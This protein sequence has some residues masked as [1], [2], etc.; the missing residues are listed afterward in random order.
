MQSSPSMQS[1]SSVQYS[2]HLSGAVQ[3]AWKKDRSFSLLSCV[4]DKPKSANFTLKL[5]TSSYKQLFIAINVHGQYCLKNIN[6]K[7]KASKTII[8]CQGN[9]I[10]IYNTDRA[11][12]M[13]WLVKNPCFIEYNIWK[14]CVLLV[15]TTLPLYHKAYMWLMFSKFA[16]LF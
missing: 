7:Y 16:L 2:S 5:L 6:K 13:L 1:S 11:L 15:F 12:C 9:I 3:R 8:Q 10:L 14:R 4:R